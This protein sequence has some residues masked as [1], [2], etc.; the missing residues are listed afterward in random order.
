MHRKG[1]E[2][3]RFGTCTGRKRRVCSELQQRQKATKPAKSA[4]ATEKAKP[5][6]KAAAAKKGADKGDR[7]NKKAEVVAMMKRAKGVTLAEIM[8]VR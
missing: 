4:K 1:T 3:Y 5:A 2:R 6:K 8:E 7:S